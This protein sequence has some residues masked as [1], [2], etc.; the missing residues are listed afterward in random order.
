MILGNYFCKWV[1]KNIVSNQTNILTQRKWSHDLIR[2][3]WQDLLY[4]G[5][6]LDTV[7][8]GPITE[9]ISTLSY[10]TSVIRRFQSGSPSGTQKTPDPSKRFRSEGISGKFILRSEKKCIHQKIYRNG[11][12]SPTIDLERHFIDIGTR[13]CSS[14]WLRFL[15]PKIFFNTFS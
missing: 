3:S 14:R 2:D 9:E 1:L 5:C 13:F 8:H 10:P 6:I 12:G 4:L 11:L 15:S 7:G